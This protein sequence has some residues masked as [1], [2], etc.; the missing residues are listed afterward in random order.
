MISLPRPDYDAIEIADNA[1]RT[2]TRRSAKAAA[3]AT[4]ALL[5]YLDAVIGAAHAKS[6]L[7]LL[8]DYPDRS[9]SECLDALGYVVTDPDPEPTGHKCH[10]VVRDSDDCD[11]AG[12]VKVVRVFADSD[13]AVEFSGNT[14]A[15]RGTHILDVDFEP[16]PEPDLPEGL[17]LNMLTADISKM[18]SRYGYDE[19]GMEHVSDDEIRPAL[20]AFIAACLANAAANKPSCPDEGACHHECHSVCFRVKYCSPLSGVYIGNEWPESVRAKH[21]GD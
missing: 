8:A 17:D 5:S 16:A 4:Q 18:L 20:P 13:A 6:L 12:C 19:W 1:R 15:G 14:D 21:A 3:N 2:L 7:D 10:V 9:L 11:N